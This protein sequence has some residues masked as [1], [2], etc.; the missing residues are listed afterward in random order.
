MALN[1]RLAPGR[2]RTEAEGAQHPCVATKVLGWPKRRKLAHAFLWEYSYTR[3]KLAQPLGQLGVVLT[4]VGARRRAAAAARMSLRRGLARRA[5]STSS[6][7]ERGAKLAQKLGQL[8]P[9]MAVSPEEC[10][11]QTCI[12][13]LRCDICSC[14][15]HILIRGQ[16]LHLMCQLALLG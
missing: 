8:Q 11:G 2:A 6:P 10:M 7:G 15:V 14:S 4:C 13:G 1:D 5:V 12:F 3:L 9:F 16:I